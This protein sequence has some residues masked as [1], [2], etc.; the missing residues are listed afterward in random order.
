MGVERSEVI[1]VGAEIGQDYYDHDH[2]DSVEETDYDKYELS[3]KSK[4]GELVYI[5]DGMSGSYF[6]VGEI[7]RVDFDGYDGL[8]LFVHDEESEEF[9]AAKKR[10]KQYIFEKFELE[11]EPKFITLTHWH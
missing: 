6:I 10:V 8:G 11:I 9:K 5:Y 7:V 4:T 1:I 2:W 3:R